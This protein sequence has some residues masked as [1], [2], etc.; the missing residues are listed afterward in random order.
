MMILNATKWQC[1]CVFHQVA[2]VQSPTVWT[3]SMPWNDWRSWFWAHCRPKYSWQFSGL[4]LWTWVANHIQTLIAPSMVLLWLSL[5][6]IWIKGAM[7]HHQISQLSSLES[8]K[9][10]YT[11]GSSFCDPL[12]FTICK[13]SWEKLI[14]LLIVCKSLLQCLKNMDEEIGVD[15]HYTD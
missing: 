13:L 8:L 11:C 7:K 9:Q 12:K 3:T 10:S 6:V 14:L 15:I 1:H 4:Y 5:L 2:R